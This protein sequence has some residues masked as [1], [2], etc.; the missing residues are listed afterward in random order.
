MSTP[1]SDFTPTT[2]S[3]VLLAQLALRPWSAYELAVQ[4]TRY[5]RLVW[6]RASRAIY[7][8]LKRLAAA[9]LASAEKG[10]T[11]RRTRTTYSLTPSGRAALDGWLELPVSP[12][13]LE[14]E[15]LQRVFSAQ[16]GR[17]EQLLAT[18]AQVRDDV[19][20]ITEFNDS[21][22]AEYVEGRAPFQRDVHVRTLV[23]DFFTQ[24]LDVAEKW[25][26]RTIAE[27]ETW[28]DL[29]P[30]GRPLPALERLKRQRYDR[31]P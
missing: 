8:E 13:S 18:L 21:V 2:T 9:G 16:L 11:G 14:F 7:A 4:R 3:Y 10:R 22:I 25:V 29:N 24:F 12:L 23:V 28:D 1:A 5:F 6:P 17:K 31:A 26:E 27:V 30:A 19:A 20:A 15:A